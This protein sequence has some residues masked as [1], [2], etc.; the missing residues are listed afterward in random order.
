MPNHSFDLNLQ[1]AKISIE[2]LVF[3][4]TIP[5]GLVQYNYCYYYITLINE[6]AF[7]FA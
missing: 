1:Q 6:D 7:M 4:N 2:T 5:V 3:I